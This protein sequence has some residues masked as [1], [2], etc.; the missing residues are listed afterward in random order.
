MT[1]FKDVFIVSG[2]GRRRR[3]PRLREHA[4]P[5]APGV[6][7]PSPVGRPRADW[8][9]GADART[10]TPPSACSAS[11]TTREWPGR[12]SCSRSSAR[13]SA[14]ARRTSTP[15]SASTSASPARRSPTPTSAARGR[16]RT[17]CVRCGQLHGR[18]PLRR[19]EHPAS[20]TTSGSR[21]GSAPRIVPERTVTDIQS[22]R[23]RA[24]A[25]TGYEVTTERSGRLVAQAATHAA[26]RAA[27]CSP[28]ARS[29]PTSCSRD[30]KHRGSLPRISDRLGELVRTNS[31]SI[32]GGHRARR[33]AATSRD[34]VAIT[35]SIYPD[36]DT[37]VE[38]VTYGRGARLDEPAVHAHD[39]RRDPAHA[40]APV[41]RAGRCATRSSSCVRS[42]R[43][44][45]RS[46]R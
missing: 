16:A 40:A 8:E 32:H 21:S 9:R 30:C 17:G 44:A 27:S 6:L 11:P 22:A 42:G 34:S 33:R 23:A 7:P 31:E 46:G 3:Q 19:Q 5:R 13:R 14:S 43:S 20:R 12:R 24:T 25:R 4:L 38:V 1:T 29:A 36:P 45:G 41:A 2:L 28:R 26:P 35:S 39:R 18:L 10:T 37:H 15:G